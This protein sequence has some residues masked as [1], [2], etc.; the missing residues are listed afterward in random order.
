MQ[1]TLSQQFYLEQLKREI[2][3][4]NK[5]QLEQIIKQF[6]G[7]SFRTAQ[8]LEAISGK[9]KDKEIQSF[10]ILAYKFLRLL[11]NVNHVDFED[12]LSEF[13]ILQRSLKPF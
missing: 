2:S 3:T 4:A 12:A 5:E 9:S 13:Y 11:G 8:I 7:L 10:N 1:L 6:A